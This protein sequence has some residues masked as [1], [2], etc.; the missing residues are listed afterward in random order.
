MFNIMEGENQDRRSSPR[1]PLQLSV[2][3]ETLSDSQPMAANLLNISMGGA[4]IKTQAMLS[5]SAP[6]IMALKL[7]GSHLQRSFRLYA[8]V[9]RRTP[10]GVGVTFFPMPPDI[11]NALIEALSWHAEQQPG[12]QPVADSHYRH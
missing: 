3:L 10:A 8:R 5:I 6:L 1:K 11:I 4:F 7:S 9:V 12:I 2:T